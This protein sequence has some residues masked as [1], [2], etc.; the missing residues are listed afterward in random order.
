MSVVATPLALICPMVRIVVRG[1]P[2]ASEGKIAH[3]EP[4]SHFMR[5]AGRE[6]LQSPSAGIEI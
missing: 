5:L 2:G 4:I 3:L 1:P 6:S